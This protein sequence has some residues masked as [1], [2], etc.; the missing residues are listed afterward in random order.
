MTEERRK[1]PDIWARMVGWVSLAGWLT[2]IGVLV[3]VQYA[4]PEMN[5]GLVRYHQID[6][7]TEWLP[8]LSDLI[9]MLLWACCGLSII[10][11]L[12][13]KR[14]MRRK[15]DTNLFNLILLGLLS[16]VGVLL[17][18]PVVVNGN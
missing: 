1:G 16:I 6:I 18:F 13:N 11:M 4:K 3:L 7:R 15:T 5:S 17:M 14:R 9:F 8:R 2:F 12:F 10:S